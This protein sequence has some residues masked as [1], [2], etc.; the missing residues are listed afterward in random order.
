MLGGRWIKSTEFAGLNSAILYRA[1]CSY[2][3]RA[4][5]SNTTT[6]RFSASVF[7]FVLPLAAAISRSTQATKYAASA[8]LRKG[9]PATDTYTGLVVAYGYRSRIGYSALSLYAAAGRAGGP[10]YFNPSTR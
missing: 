3:F 9:A 8:G 5:S 7:Q 1:I 6:V 10:F 4:A 2:F